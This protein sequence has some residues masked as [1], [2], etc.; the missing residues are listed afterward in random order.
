MPFANPR[1]STESCGV[2]RRRGA[3]SN[4][5]VDDRLRGSHAEIEHAEA[6]GGEAQLEDASVLELQVL[7]FGGRVDERRAVHV[8]FLRARPDPGGN[9]GSDE[10]AAS[11]VRTTYVWRRD[12]VLEHGAKGWDERV[13]AKA[14]ARDVWLPAA[15]DGPF[16]VFVHDVR[17]PPVE[18]TAASS[19]S[20][21]FEDR[22]VLE[23]IRHVHMPA[24]Q[25]VKGANVGWRRAKTRAQ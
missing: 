3:D 6:V 14:K 8:D 7:A 10:D 25:H 5:V 13:V 22:S 16:V 20:R 4:Q 2:Q 17:C 9:R 12:E 24:A 18:K 1:D 23:E 15:R 19:V 21:G 11:D